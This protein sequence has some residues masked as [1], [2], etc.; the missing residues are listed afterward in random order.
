MLNNHPIEPTE[1]RLDGKECIDTSPWLKVVDLLHMLEHVGPEI[2]VF[3]LTQVHSML[4]ISRIAL[5]HSNEPVCDESVWD[6]EG[7]MEVMRR[8]R[9]DSICEQVANLAHADELQ[10]WR[11][12]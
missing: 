9:L 6:Q 3:E 5:I 12:V 2:F 4:H 7:V 11:D 1:R 10:I 8:V